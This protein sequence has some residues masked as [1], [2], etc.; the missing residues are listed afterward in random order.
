MDRKCSIFFYDG[1]VGI[2]PTIINLAKILDDRGYLVTVFATQNNV[3]QPEKL[4]SQVEILYFQKKFKIIDFFYNLNLKNIA[5]FLEICFFTLQ[6]FAHILKDSDRS[7]TSRDVINIVVDSND[8]LIGLL[9]FWLFKQK[10]LFLSLEI[11]EVKTGFIYRF[12]FKIISHIAYRKADCVIIQDE[13]RFQTLSECYQYT[14]PQV[15]YLPNCPLKDFHPDLNKENF[16]REKFQ[17]SQEQFPHLVLLAG[18]L[19]DFTCS[20][21]LARSFTAIDGGCALVFHGAWTGSSQEK[22]SYQKSMQQLNDKNLFLSLNPVPYEE[23]D[24]IYASSTIGLALYAAGQGDN[25]AKIAMAS[26]KLAHFLKHGKPILISNLSS[27]VEFNKKYQ[28]GVVVDDASNPQEIQSAIARILD[29]YETYSKNAK[30]SFEA[31]FDF[32][33]KIEP[34]L[35][36]IDTLDKSNSLI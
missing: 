32:D 13:D 2:A 3:P 19:N 31:E 35:E 7:K 12:I 20:Q 23:L 16:F 22:E 26:G 25:F 17:L 30:I 29:S 33:R 5:K 21:S 4:G 24:K 27:L 9:C 14:H 10:F 34:I 28:V 1:Y 18:M 36:F 8:L 11:P 15:F 6:C